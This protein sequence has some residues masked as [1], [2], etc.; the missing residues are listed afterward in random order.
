MFPMPAVAALLIAKT[1]L[2]AESGVTLALT[3]DSHLSALDPALAT[4]VIT[5]LGNLI[6]NA[7]DASVGSVAAQVDGA[8]R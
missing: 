6:D 3:G 1:S 4:D 8:Y 2:A 5:L 7:V